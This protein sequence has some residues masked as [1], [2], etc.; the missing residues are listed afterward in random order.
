MKNPTSLRKG[1]ALTLNGLINIID[2]EMTLTMKEAAPKSS[3]MA[4]DPEPDFMAP[5][6]EN[7]SG[8]PF[9]K[10]RKVTPAWERK[11]RS[12]D[13]KNNE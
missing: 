12:A 10:A 4:R 13:C 8:D 5:K 9:P 6:V 2:P 3:P 1:K 11:R 7:T